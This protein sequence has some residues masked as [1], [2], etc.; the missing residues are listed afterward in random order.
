MG[1]LADDFEWKRSLRES[2]PFA[3]V[4]LSHVVETIMA[5][6]KPYYQ[7]LLWNENKGDIRHIHRGRATTNENTAIS[8]VLLKVQEP[9]QLMGNFTFE[10]F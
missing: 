1:L 9:L 8:Y 7:L 10:A 4:I 3:F 2:F 5:Y 6:F